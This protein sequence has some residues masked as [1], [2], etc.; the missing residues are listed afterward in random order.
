MQL[1][2]SFPVF[3]FFSFLWVVDT[4]A[5]FYLQQKPENKK[6]LWLK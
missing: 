4:N 2:F 6:G 5:S 3:F 1:K